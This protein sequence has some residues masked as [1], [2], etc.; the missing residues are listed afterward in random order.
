MLRGDFDANRDTLH[1]NASN[2]RGIQLKGYKLLG[3][4]AGRLVAASAGSTAFPDM[5][6]S[7]GSLLGG[8][9]GLKSIGET[10]SEAFND[11]GSS[12]YSCPIYSSSCKPDPVADE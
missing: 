6:A 9:G 7:L 12:S 11:S 10:G 4:Q 8:K 2:V 5:A 1:S 3:G